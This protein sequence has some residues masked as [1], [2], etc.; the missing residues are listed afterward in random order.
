[1]KLISFRIHEE[2]TTAS[3]IKNSTRQIEDTIMFRKFWPNFLVKI[4]M[5][6]YV[7]CYEVYEEE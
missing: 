3:W 7:K 6:F 4:I 5:K 2:A 1:M